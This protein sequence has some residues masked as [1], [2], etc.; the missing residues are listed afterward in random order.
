MFINSIMS[1]FLK[2]LV[3]HAAKFFVQTKK[4]RVATLTS[5]P[6]CIHI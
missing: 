1:T 2:D 4:A 3:A 6:L 5:I